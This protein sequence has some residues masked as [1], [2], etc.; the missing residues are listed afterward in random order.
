VPDT[1]EV[2]AAEEALVYSSTAGE[3]GLEEL[4]PE[5]PTLV[6]ENG[7][8]HQYVVV[9]DLEEFAQKVGRAVHG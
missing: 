3:S 8:S 7:A 4:D 9:G 2:C 1:I 6:I 5:V